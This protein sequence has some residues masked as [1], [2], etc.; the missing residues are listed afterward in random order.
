MRREKRKTNKKSLSSRM[1]KILVLSLMLIA[2][3]A[4]ITLIV[5]Q[6]VKKQNS[7]YLS[8]MA[9]LYIQSQDTAFFKLSRQMLSI[10]VGDG[11]MK[12][13]IREMMAVLETSR[14]PLELNVARSGLKNDFLEYTWDYGTDYKFFAFLEKRDVY[15]DLN[16]VGPREPE[17]EA[18]FRRLLEENLLNGYSAKA[19]WTAIHCR[20]GNYILKVMHSNGRY[21]GC[22]IRADALLK[23]LEGLNF[24]DTGFAVLLDGTNT[25]VTEV[26]AEGQKPL[27]QYLA[28]G[29]ARDHLVIKNDFERAP[30]KIL[31]FMDNLGIYERYLAIQAALFV[32]GAAIL[33]T[34]IFINQYLQRRVLRPIQEFADNLLK[35]SDDEQFIFDITSSELKELEL[36]NEQFRNLLRQIKRLKITLYENE[37]NRQEIQ[38]DYLQLQ[39]KPHFY[40]NCLNYIYQMVELGYYEYAKR[41]SVIT[42]DYLRYL[43][44]S[45]MDFVEIKNELQHVR[46]YLEIQRMRYQNAFTYYIEQEQETEDCGIPPLMIQTFAE[47]AVNYTVTLDQPS[48]IT[49]L[50]CEEAYQGERYVSISISDTG[51]GFSQEVLQQLGREE[52]FSQTPDG[53]RVGITNCLRRMKY[54]YGGKGF[55]RFYNNPLGGAVVE[56]HLPADIGRREKL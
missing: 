7:Q 51:T 35:Y 34:L 48:E 40:L 33:G 16:S 37:L 22:Y 11:G 31:L 1:K 23:P 29:T 49:I 39:I 18:G 50:V 19:K 2:V 47:N 36:A 45:S 56:L 20:G 44:Q 21:L 13:D 32:L 53:H 9:E 25:P 14:D 43:F 38:M 26:D 4:S 55:A 52:R 17:M 3:D 12:S 24:A 6:N 42:S 28:N 30:F 5:I 15:I 27:Q 8:N 10:L 46:N 54:F 41:M